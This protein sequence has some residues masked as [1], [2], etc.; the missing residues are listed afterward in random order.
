[1]SGTRTKKPAAGEAWEQPPAVD[2]PDWNAV[3]E[4]L[5]SRPMDWLRVYSDRPSTWADAI[6]RGRIR[7][8]RPDLGFE[9]ATTNNTRNYPR[10]CTLFMRFNPDKVDPLT[11][12]VTGRN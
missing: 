1:M 6:S 8:L 5:R 2:K 3:A 11:E 9:A 10:T 7:A 4:T 12:L